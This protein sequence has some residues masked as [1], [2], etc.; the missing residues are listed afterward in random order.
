MPT[1]RK[2]SLSPEREDTL[3]YIYDVIIVGAGPCG[4]ATAARLRE[5]TP[6]ALFT[7]EE[8]HRYHWIKKHAANAAIK[9]SK[10]GH[11][12]SLGQQ[13]PP[14]SRSEPSMLVLD[15]SGK[16]WLS[17]WKRLFSLLEISHLR[18]PMFFHPDPH[19][20]DGLLAYAHAV[21]RES[22]C[23]EIAGCVGKELSKHQMKKRRNKRKPGEQARPTIAIDER[24]RKDYFVPPS[25][26]FESYCSF[27]AKRYDLQSPD[28]IQKASVSNIEYDY[29]PQLSSEEK[30]FTLHTD[31]KTYFAKSVV[32]AVGAGN[33]PS[34]P[35]PFPRNGCPSACHA[36]QPLDEALQARMRAKK[37]TNVLVIGGGLTSAQ[38]S[39][40]AIRRG[41]TKVHHI[42]RGP[43]KVKP[44]DVDLSWMGKFR[45]HEKASFWSADT[46]EE[47]SQLITTARNGGSI[48]PH[49]SK[50]LHHHL[51]TSKKLTLHTHTTI[52]TAKF[53]PLTQTWK[54]LTSPPISE[55]L[56]EFHH[57]YFA[58]GIQSNILT[59][60]YLT[61]LHA[62]YPIKIH[63]GLPAITEDLMWR[64]DIPLFV[65]GRFAGLRLGPGA[66]NLEGARV[67][68]ERIVW[69]LEEVLGRG[70]KERGVWLVDVWD[71]GSRVSQALWRFLD[72]RDIE[73]WQLLLRVRDVRDQ[74][75]YGSYQA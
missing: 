9:S 51:T 28:L 19:D 59:L 31:G 35:A 32:L 7:D 69:G 39:D 48:T 38:I 29:I 23:L 67:G 25:D 8:H 14:S 11:T 15:N 18:S 26:L 30:F 40:R 3:P 52:T 5:H 4:L 44:F 72:E 12:R 36:F 6:S 65:T 68:A 33:A 75:P 41:A 43:M 62:K 53:S 37:D 21:G 57:I 50:R 74:I 45:N 55:P 13:K 27:I 34:I 66:G 73:W 56:P 71:C 16:E 64:E 54:I 1:S 17:K 2:D 60:P 10:T 70:E 49:F 46:D 58:T 61:H 42:M 20:R 47:R 63:D 22:E 24:D